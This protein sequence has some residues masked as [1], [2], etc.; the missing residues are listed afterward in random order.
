LSINLFD[1]EDFKKENLQAHDLLKNNLPDEEFIHDCIRE[2]REY[3]TPR[4]FDARDTN[5][6]YQAQQFASYEALIRH[7]QEKFYEC[8]ALDL[9]NL[10]NEFSTENQNEAPSDTYLPNYEGREVVVVDRNPQTS[11]RGASEDLSPRPNQ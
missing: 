11:A 5:I 8:F 4:Y 9:R 6:I 2:C 3:F 7:W 10:R 1:L